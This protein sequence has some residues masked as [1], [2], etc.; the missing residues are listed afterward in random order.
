MDNQSI[1]HTIWNE[2]K[3]IVEIKK[4]YEIEEVLLIEVKVCVDHIH[5]Q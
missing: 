4:I 2:K 1:Q 3:D 5:M